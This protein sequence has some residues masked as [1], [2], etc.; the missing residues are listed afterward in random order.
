MLT[1]SYS[2]FM[3]PHSVHVPAR[4][5]FRSRRPHL[6]L[7]PVFVS[8]ALVFTLLRFPRCARF[9]GG[10][11]P[12]PAPPPMKM[13][14]RSRKQCVGYTLK[15][16]PPALSALRWMISVCGAFESVRMSLARD[17]DAFF[18]LHLR[19]SRSLECPKRTGA[20]YFA[21][22]YSPTMAPV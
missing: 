3:P 5:I 15:Q 1:D 16:T 22:P 8:A 13:C 6:P 11:F 2:P 12:A 14:F 20:F 19:P 18:H 4:R 17:D 7:F 9:S 10:V 21:F